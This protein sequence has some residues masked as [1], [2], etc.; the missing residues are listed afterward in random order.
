M[1]SRLELRRIYYSFPVQL[2]LMHIKKNL[3]LVSFWLLLIGIISQNLFNRFGV[4]YLFLDPE[5]LGEVNF[6]SFFI[7]GLSLGAFVMS[8]NISSYILNS[9]RFPFLATLS[10]PFQKYCFNNFV[11]PLAFV[12]VYVYFIVSFQIN[13]Q[14]VETSEV[15]LNTLGL[16]AGIVIIIF[17]TIRYFLITNKDIYK[18]YGIEENKDEDLVS[19]HLP[20]RKKKKKTIVQTSQWP[21][22]TYLIF[23]FKVKLVRSVRHYKDYMLLSVFKQNHINAAVVELIVFSVFIMLGLFST[24]RY[25]II[26]AS[27][28]LFLLFTMVLM[29]SGVFRFWFRS[30][31]N[32]ALIGLFLVLN[33]L[34]QFDFINKRNSAYGLDYEG[35]KASYSR[36]ALSRSANLDLYKEDTAHTIEVLNRWLVNHQNENNQ[37]PKLVMISVSGGGLRSMV[38]S[39]RSMQVLDSIMQ[40]DLMKQTRFI[41]GSSGG[42]ISAA[43]Y[44]ELFLRNELKNEK[45]DQLIHSPYLENMGKDILNAVAFTFTV[46][47]LVMNLQRFEDDGQSYIQDRAYAFETQLNENTGYVLHKRLSDYK[48]PEEEGKIPMLIISPTIINDGRILQISPLPLSYM[49]QTPDNAMGFESTID[50]VEFSRFFENQ[51]AGHTRFTSVLRMN[52]AFPYIMTASSLP[53]EPTV[54][55]MD[56]GISDNFGIKNAT[57]IMFTF[58]EW[59]AENTSGVILIQIRDSYKN[60]KIEEN[61]VKTLFDKITYPI[62]NVSGNFIVMQDYDNDKLLHYAKQ[63]LKEKLEIVTLQIPETDDKL[64]LSWHLTDVEKNFIKDALSSEKNKQEL[65]RFSK[66]IQ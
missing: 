65:L 23:P 35:E 21:V 26:P 30:W 28:S 20:S 2:V 37:K 18:L 66:M 33:F 1:L 13:N 38:F 61:S 25:F 27:A 41:T 5:Y 19:D 4:P 8:Y 3:L 43:Y 53:S 32:V 59:I 34:S 29:L 39:Y 31:S 22:E 42:I 36:E 45:Q 58:K 57:R 15:M 7:V 24:N 16:L 11:F 9:F 64:A 12:L 54:E 10:K 47:D 48:I 6:L 60:P 56:S 55:V 50:G 14:L 63:V 49:I 40:G 17:M 51:N 52:S 62:R 44:R 46:S